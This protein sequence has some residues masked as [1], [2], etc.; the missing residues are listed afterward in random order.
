MFGARVSAFAR[1]TR[2]DRDFELDAHVALLT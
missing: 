1:S 2:L